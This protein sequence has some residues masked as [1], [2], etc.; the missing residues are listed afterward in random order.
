VK[1]KAKSKYYKNY[2]MLRIAKKRLINYILR[3]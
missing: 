2:N 1:I 3:L